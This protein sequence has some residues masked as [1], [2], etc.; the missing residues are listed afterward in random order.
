MIALGLFSILLATTLG[1]Y[2]QQGEA[3]TQG[4]DRMTLMQNLRYGISAL[5]QNLRTAG[6]GVPTKQ[7]VMVYA[8]EYGFAFNADY[9][10]RVENDF[11]AVYY[12][13]LLPESAVSALS[14]ARKFTI[15]GSVF[16]YPDSAYFVGSTNSPAE[17]ITFFFALDTSTERSDDYV[18]YR[19]VNELPPEII[20][21]K[22]LKTSGPF[23]EYFV[24]WPEGSTEP[25]VAMPTSK[26]PVAHTVAIH[27]SPG[28]TGTV[29]RVDSIRAVRVNFAAT[30]GHE[31]PREIT[32]QVSRLIRLPN[33]GLGLVRNCGNKP[34]LNTAI[35]ATGIAPTETTSG[36]IQL[37]WGQATDEVSGE[38]DVLRYVVWRR[39]SGTLPWGDPLVSIPPGSLSY[40]YRDF[41]AEEDQEYDYALA[42]QD[43]TPQYSEMATTM[44]A[45]WSG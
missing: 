5:E 42:A 17:T 29:A 3:F 44:G 11:F 12:D 13:P 8:G 15:P 10:T 28:D 25:I 30:N 24:S 40:A 4:N 14:P 38:Q 45:V 41:T 39:P 37:N 9:A 27:G 16:A 6:V 34:F 26:L 2:K 31:P 7:P 21:T 33:A 22:L 36:H 23:F 32:R 35:S 18:L 19:Q 1:F 43:C 20:A